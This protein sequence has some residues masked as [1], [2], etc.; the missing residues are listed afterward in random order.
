[1]QKHWRRS[2]GLHMIFNKKA[3]NRAYRMVHREKLR[4][5]AA[6]YYAAH[7]KERIAY[8]LVY[9]ATHREKIRAQ[10]RARY[11]AYP[12]KARAHCRAY[13]TAHLEE[14][15]AADRIRRAAKK[16]FV[17]DKYGGKC[18]CCGESRIEF[19]SIDHIYG[20]RKKRQGETG[21][22]FYQTLLREPY[23]PDKYRVLCYNCNLSLGHLGYCPHRP[24]ERQK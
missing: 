21:S 8:S 3:Y 11:A 7:R 6:A 18:A 17:I 10:C 23:S 20:G 1:M 14:R 2:R 24:G 19:M 5:C 9:K 13:R 4:L 12:E 15:R 16:K 22:R